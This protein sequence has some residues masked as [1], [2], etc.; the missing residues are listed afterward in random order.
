MTSHLHGRVFVTRG[1]GNALFLNW[2]ENQAEVETVK[3]KNLI[4]L[5]AKHIY[6]CVFSQRQLA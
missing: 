1:D 3:E 4:I 5:F 6:I 2:I